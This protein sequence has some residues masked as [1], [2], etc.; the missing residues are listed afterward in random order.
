M[1]NGRYRHIFLQNPPHSSRFKNPRRGAAGPRIPERDRARH[2]AYLKG[3]LEAAWAEAEQRQAIVHV[4][5]DGVYLDFVSDPGADLVLKSL[6]YRRSGIRLLNVRREDEGGGQITKATVYVPHLRRGYFLRK[7]TKYAEEEASRSGKPKNQNLINSISDIRRS[8][9]ESF[10]QDDPDLLP[11][12]N[13]KWVEVWLSNES[14]ETIQRF[15]GILR[16]Q[17]IHKAEGVLKFPER[18]VEMIRVRRL[19]L[20]TL[21]EVSDDIAELRLAKEVA[22]VFIELENR[23]QLERVRELLQRTEIDEDGQIAV[24]ILDTGI[25]NGHLL[26]QPLLSDA[27]RHSAHPDWGM[28]DHN[29]H[30]TRMAGLAAY[31]NLLEALQSRETIR[32]THRLESAKILPPQP[33]Q[34]DP[35]L[36]GYI[37]SQGI[38][39][40][41]I[42]A[43]ERKR[44]ICL[45][46]TATDFRDLGRPSSWS[47]KLDEVTS[48]ADEGLRRLVVVSGGNVGNAEEWR[49]YPDS[50]MTNEVHDPGQAWNA[51]TVGAYTEKVRITDPALHGYQPVAP[52]GGL[53]PFSTTSLVWQRKWPIKP[54]VLFEGGNVA[55]GPN[56]SIF[57]PDDLALLSTYHNPTV[58]QFAPFSMTSAA[59]AQASWMAA[60]IQREYPNA[61]P[62][63]VRALI[64]HSAT[65]TEAMKTQFLE[66][67]SKASY[68][69]LLRT[70]GYGVPNLDHALF[71]AVNLLTLVSQA[72]LQPYDR[73]EAKSYVTREMHLYDLP[74]PRG[75]LLDLEETQVQMRV[76]L[77]Y[78]IEP[79]PGEVGWQDRYRYPSFA[80]RFAVKGPTESE[81]EFVR[82]VNSEAR[83]D[84]EHPG[85][86]GPTDKWVIGE[87]TR[88]VGSIHSDIWKGTAADLADSNCIAVFPAVGWWRERSHL[89]KWNKRCRYSLVVSIQTPEQTVDIYTPVAVQV[90]VAVPIQ[91]RAL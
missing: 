42:E 82:R 19:Q 50:N 20:E 27:D 76:T 51:L 21:I 83:E 22:S 69:K 52:Y 46:V 45:A 54:E 40:A 87:N 23:E 70:C 61:W 64:V 67:E 89:G 63:T 13:A 35:K 24:C 86:A 29:G 49:R 26:I 59:T 30:G 80:L 11:G 8:V 47:A 48:G 62:E 81:N 90:G 4:E 44:V 15:D 39:L 58:A 56:D 79:G 77:S 53:S 38:S 60:K 14:P 57:D 68:R 36:W 1:P 18:A 12:A 9:L 6:E 7:I 37:T 32:V 71:C 2:S 66:N 31:G 88:D 28:H 41:E 10:W 73:N 25:N 5:R 85:T 72:E 17:D 3:K 75:A 33:E 91:I 43:P 55:T 84:G 65:W 74:W 16:D 78:F 34:T